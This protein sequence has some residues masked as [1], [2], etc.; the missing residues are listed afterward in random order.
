MAKASK[1]TVPNLF[2]RTIKIKRYVDGKPA[3]VH[4][5][6]Y[7]TCTQLPASAKQLKKDGKAIPVWAVDNPAL[8]NEAHAA[9]TAVGWNGTGFV[10]VIFTEAQDAGL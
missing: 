10:S 7:G 5:V 6:A 3:V 8:P 9:L 1:V 2:Q 4:A